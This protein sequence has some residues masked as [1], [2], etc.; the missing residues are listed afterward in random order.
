VPDVLVYHRNT[1]ATTNPLGVKGVGEAGVIP[2]PAVIA[3]AIGD[4][5]GIAI[6]EVPVP[7]PTLHRIVTEARAAAARHGLVRERA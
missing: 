4:A 5:I 6:D 2:V 7:P 1:P 3:N